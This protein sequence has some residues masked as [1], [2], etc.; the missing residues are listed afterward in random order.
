M[1]TR[2]TLII[3]ETDESSSIS[4]TKKKMKKWPEKQRMRDWEQSGK[5]REEA[6]RT[7]WSDVSSATES[8]ARTDPSRVPLP[9]DMGALAHSK[10]TCDPGP[11]GRS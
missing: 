5:P 11:P 1:K 10:C 2:R 4:S 8:S 9:R 7:E 3:S 6:G